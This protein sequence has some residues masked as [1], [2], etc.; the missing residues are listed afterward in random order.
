MHGW[1][2]PPIA[3]ASVPG[4][5][6]A[7]GDGDFVGPITAGRLAHAYDYLR[8][9]VRARIRHIGRSQ[10][11][12]LGSGFVDLADVT[13]SLH[14]TQYLNFYKD[15][16]TNGLI[17]ASYWGLGGVPSAGANAAA[18]PGGEAPTRATTGALGQYNPP[19]S[20][21]QH[22]SRAN[23][24]TDGQASSYLLYD[25]LFQV[26]KTMNS[27]TAESVTGVPTRYQSSTSTDMDYAAGNFCF[28]EVGG[29]ALAAT[30]HNWTVCQYR[31]QTGTDAQSF[32]SVAGRSAA[33]ARTIDLPTSSWFMPLSSADT[34]VIDLAQ[35]QC[36]AL[37][38]TGVINFVI[39]HPIAWF[40]NP[41]INNVFQSDGILT[42]FNMVRI[43]DDAALTILDIYRTNST[44]STVTGNIET[45][46]G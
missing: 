10:M 12:K 15:V 38:A 1:Y 22:F 34:G 39:G 28:P 9:R 3:L 19:A 40:T 44:A 6:W 45:I 35:I 29:T 27:T 13:S 24:F 31:N 8:D 14:T 21:T 23:T 36:D 5:V 37:V 17:T 25:R 11:T 26:N 18:A 4:S 2:G 16:T 20:N 33:Q 30:A 41:I 42:A 32:P 7:T 43:F 46:W